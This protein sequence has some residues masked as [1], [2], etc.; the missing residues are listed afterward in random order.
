MKTNTA[1]NLNTISCPNASFTFIVL[2]HNKKSN[3]IA[4]LTKLQI[5]DIIELVFLN[6]YL[7]LKLN[8]N[9]LHIW[10]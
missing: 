10:D 8:D 2:G 6:I 5:N 3:S 9:I 4:M 1:I 7:I